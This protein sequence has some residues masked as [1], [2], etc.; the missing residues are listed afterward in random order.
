MERK[1][2]IVIVGAGFGGL[3]AAKALRRSPFDITVIDRRNYHLFQPLLYQVATGVLSPANIASPIRG[4]LSRQKNTRVLLGEVIDFDCK[5]QEVILADGKVPYDALVVATG[6]VNNYFGN[7]HWREH[8]P[9]L[10]SID[11][12]TEIRKRIL[13]A[14]EKAERTNNDVDRKRLLTFVIIGSGPTGVEL[15]GAISDIAHNTLRRDFR[16]INPSTARILIV[17]M[18]DRPLTAYAPELSQKGL[19]ALHR[20]HVEVKVSTKVVDISADGIRLV[21]PQGEEF[22]PSATKIWAAGVSASALGQ[23]LANA[24]GAPLDQRGRAIVAPDL[25]LPSHPNIFVIGDLANFSHGRQQPLPGLAPIAMQQGR[26]L[27]RRLEEWARGE[28][29][30]KPFRYFDKGSMAVIGR[31]AAVAEVGKLKMSGILAWLGW[32]FIHLIYITQ[33]RNRLL[34]LVQWGWTFFTLD[35]SARLITNDDQT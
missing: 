12:A 34:V 19:Q 7:D 8:A 10:K 11:D 27:K 24:T 9:G 29:A 21:G 25:S 18:A 33:F 20:L 28:K 2:R 14:F 3:A 31:Y 26:Y 16:S 32:L 35:R 17:E 22:V 30:S 1:K 15:A 23:K 5:N 13:S 4:I 6:V